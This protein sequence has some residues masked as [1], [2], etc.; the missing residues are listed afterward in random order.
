MVHKTEEK[1]LE[2][3]YGTAK[4]L[5]FKDY[6]NQVVK[7][8]KREEVPKVTEDHLAC[9]SLLEKIEE[10][11][12]ED[13]KITETEVIAQNGVMSSDQV[14]NHGIGPKLDAEGIAKSSNPDDA[15]FIVD[16]LAE[17]KEHIESVEELLSSFPSSS[18]MESVVNSIFRVFH[19]I[20][21]LALFL[22]FNGVGNFTHGFE[23][24]LS[25]VR[26]GN[27]ELTEERFKLIQSAV[28]AL[29]GLIQKVELSLQGE[30]LVYPEE[31][32]EVYSQLG[33]DGKG[34]E[35]DTSTVNS[36]MEEAS[37]P[38]MLEDQS[39]VEDAKVDAPE[40][41]AKNKK[42]EEIIR[43]STSKLDD[44][45]DSIG[46]MVI[47]QSMIVADP[48]IEKLE[49]AAFEKKLA[50]S[51]LLLRQIQ[52]V[53]MVLRMVP[54]KGVFQKMSRIVRDLSNKLNKPI[55]FITVGEDTELDRG[56]V[57]LVSDPLMHMVRNAIDHG[58]ES[59]EE[60]LASGKPE[61]AKLTLRSFNRGGAIF[62]EVQED[63][64]GLDTA[65][66]RE[67]AENLG[68]C[69]PSDDISDTEVNRFIFH[70]GFSTA[71]EVTDVSGRGVG[72]DVVRQN[73]EN[74]RGSIVIDTEKGRGSTFSIRLPLTLAIIDG[75]VVRSA[76]SKYIIPTLSILQSF[77][78]GADNLVSQPD[79]TVLVKLLGDLIPVVGLKQVLQLES[80]K[81]L[82]EDSIVV[83]VE[84]MDGKRLGIIVDEVVGQQQIVIK[85]IGEWL[86]EL[87]GVTGGA[88]MN[89]GTISLILDVLGLMNLYGENTLAGTLVEY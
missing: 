6:F 71:A 34:E 77:K 63:G 49:D 46:E 69:S 54:V 15:E 86:G 52:E 55:D 11:P 44:L 38:L 58:I 50:Q 27:L 45:I 73:I 67:K 4:L 2:K 87:S 78:V 20:K 76:Q 66:I 88:I 30:P 70:P 7:W 3:S 37:N 36:P 31:V 41:K 59:K 29:F 21:G 9:L 35:F 12:V 13:V 18:D 24:L 47:A 33:I 5:I 1:F 72:M 19:T 82:I 42:V 84:N 60:R 79:G 28:D 8:F 89:D 32:F 48:A 56:I 62:I 26:K 39:V 57:E 40:K 65:K 14:N 68:L 83:V 25:D 53:S 43:V 61:K 17:S 75:M 22:G 16:F 64:R 23:N 85:N 81:V 10:E 80:S 51:N 74:L